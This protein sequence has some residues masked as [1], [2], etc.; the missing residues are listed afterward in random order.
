MHEVLEATRRVALEGVIVTGSELVGL[1]PKAA[2]VQAG[3]FYL[4]KERANPGV[5]ER[6][7]STP[8]YSMGLRDVGEFDPASRVIEYAIGGDG[9]LVSMTG[10]QF[11][12]TLGSSAPAP[13]AARCLA[14][15]AMS[16]ALSAMVGSLTTGKKGYEAQFDTHCSNSVKAQALKDAFLADIDNDTA[17]FNAIMAAMKLPEDGADQAARREAMTEATRLAIEVPLEV[18]ERS[19]RHRLRRGRCDGQQE[20]SLRRRRRGLTSRPRP[21]GPTTSSSASMGSTTRPTLRPR[22]RG[23]RPLWPRLPSGWPRSP[24]PSANA[25]RLIPS[26]G[27]KRPLHVRVWVVSQLIHAR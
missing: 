16:T 13:A 20:C 21:R 26:E 18:L 7:W 8:P 12:D 27:P 4:D 11:I 9:P 14:L 25:S 24:R 23:R 2:M 1:V 10:R 15:G 19:V 3:R 6:S 5:S 17:A 22:L